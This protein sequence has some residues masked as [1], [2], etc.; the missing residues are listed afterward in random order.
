MAREDKLYN[1]AKQHRLNAASRTAKAI[2]PTDNDG[3][4][5][6]IMIQHVS[7]SFIRTDMQ[8]EASPALK[9]PCC[10]SN[11]STQ[12][13]RKHTTSIWNEIDS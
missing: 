7:D 12:L 6:A 10:D 11:P 9:Q 5:P 4:E 2:V 8:A 13:P 1:Q 3:E